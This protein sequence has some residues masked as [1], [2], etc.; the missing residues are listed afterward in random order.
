MIYLFITGVRL[1]IVPPAHMNIVLHV[2]HACY[3]CCMYIA[4]ADDDRMMTCQICGCG[5]TR[6]QACQFCV[7][8]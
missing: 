8:E 6:N 4:P 1:R 3:M 7:G 5:A 2:I